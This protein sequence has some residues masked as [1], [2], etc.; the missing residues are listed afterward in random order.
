MLRILVLLVLVLA[1]C[2]AHAAPP[3]PLRIWQLQDYQMD[4]MKRLIR[5]AAEQKVNRV[6]LSHHIVM[7]AE[8]VLE[9]PN[10]AE[11]INEIT[12]YAHTRGLK[13]DIWTHEL[14]GIT[15]DMRSDGE[16]NLDDGRVW[17]FVAAKYR[18]LFS[19]CPDIDGLVLTLHE[20]QVKLWDSDVRSALSPAERV[21]KLIDT[22]DEV[23]R[24]LGKALFVR[25]F[26]YE[27]VQLQYLVDGIRASKA[28]VTAMT[29]CV[30]HDWQPYYP[31]NPAIGMFA[32]KKQIVEF[33]LGY[34]FL[35]LSRIPYID[36]RQLHQRL[37]YGLG[38]GISGAV[39]RTERLKW[40][41]VDTPN[42]A[43]ID[44]FTRVLTDPGLDVTRLYKAWLSERYPAEAVPHLYAAFMR[45]FDIVN[46]G[47]F[48]LGF[49][50]TN[51]SLLPDYGYAT[52]SLTGRTTA[53]WDPAAKATEQ[54]LFHPTNSTVRRISAQKDEALRLVDQSLA[55]IEKAR[56]HLAQRDY[57]ELRGL[58][59]REKAMVQVWKPAME[60]IFGIS[61][62]K[63]TGA[64][65]DRQ[66]LLAAAGRLEQAANANRGHLIEMASDYAN[67]R[68]TRNLDTA[69]G[70]VKLARETAAGK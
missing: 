55:D 46:Q 12:K 30:P 5:M 8:Q 67:P 50:V 56:P 9:H 37:R 7:Y 18:R 40:R 44:V 3:L 41:A 27:P 22:L 17:E 59:L 68:S 53:K 51:H 34:E 65:S 60:V 20:T 36:I 1:S 19:I 35:G 69:A 61:V 31:N 42:Q 54:D 14:E 52:R 21:T 47:Y 45:T 32:P 57:E 26:A 62:L 64:E 58:L 25:T 11:D 4:H 28:D 6:Q 66:F 49:W 13:V 33:D 23:C 16:V 24:P 43:N 10:L 29:K 39:L 2:S 38:K 63:A 70:L 48:V 15:D